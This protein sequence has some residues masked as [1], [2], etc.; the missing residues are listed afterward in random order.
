M[1]DRVNILR[2]RMR[3]R[4]LDRWAVWIFLLLIPEV[5][6]GQDAKAVSSVNT[7][8]LPESEYPYWPEYRHLETEDLKSI[9][10]QQ[11]I[12]KEHT[13]DG[14]DWSLPDHVE[15]AG[16]SL[17]GLQRI[18]GL[19]K[20][21]I[22]LDLNFKSNGVGLL[23]VS[24]RDIEP[25]EGEYDFSGIIK[26]IKQGNEAGLDVILRILTCSK[27]RG[28][29]SK[30]S[31]SGEAP[32]WLEDRGVTLLPR[33]AQKDN[34]NFDP[35][36][37]EFHKRYLK[38]I[39]EMSKAG[40]PKMVKAAY[41]GYASHS[42]GDEGI[43]PFKESEAEKNDAVPHVRDRLDAWHRAFRGMENKIFMG[44]SS[45]YGFDKGFGVRRGF[46]EM[47]LYNI[48]NNEL[49]QFIDKDGYLR[50][51]ENAPVIRHRA[52]NGEVNEEY[53]DAWATEGRGYRFGATTRSFPYRYFT[54]TLRAL[55]MRCTY[56]HT[57][58]HLVPEM[59]P[60]LSLQLARTVDDTPDVWT[61]LR[62]SY[63][64]S[65]NYQNNDALGRPITENEKKEGIPVRNFERWLQQRDAVGYETRPAMKIQQSIKMWMVQNDKYYDSIARSGRQIGFNIDDR[66]LGKNGNM[67]VKVTY[68]DTNSG[69]LQLVFNGGNSIK[70]VPLSGDGKLKTT[71]FS[72]SGLQPQSMDHKFDF[73]LKG[74]TDTDEITVSMVRAVATK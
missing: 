26:R 31:T 38:L 45:H 36:H 71:T 46:V 25:N 61:F 27:S 56:I 72:M 22:P 32:L 66:W 63:M 70:T 18:M 15:P 53:E 1:N 43:G 62:T 30:A 55:Q 74:G 40:I 59:L 10:A 13:V 20:P 51:D 37:P 14:W 54:S 9:R 3:T 42:L 21:F 67:A 16:Q 11:W 57:T 41:V 4:G 44:G 29:G 6:L 49:G 65:G 58:G 8:V 7:N 23:W 34:L 12:G 35:A 17:V 24:W 5:A 47:Y 69:A 2:M 52:F 39:D 19:E 73:I 64:K 68:L 28:S 50:V 33:K 48:P 60:F